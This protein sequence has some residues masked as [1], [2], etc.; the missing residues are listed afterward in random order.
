MRAK[1]QNQILKI[2]LV[3][4]AILILGLSV[5]VATTVAKNK[6]GLSAEASL[7]N[8]Y[9]SVEQALES[10]QEA[11]SQE[12]AS[13][14]QQLAEQSAA[15]ESNEARLNQTIAD[16]NKQ[17]SIKH[18]LAAATAATTQKPPTP[19]VASTQKTPD[20]SGKT[21]Y[22]TFD[23]GPSPRTPEILKI[24]KANG[25]KAT[26]FVINGGKYNAYMKDIVADGH[27]IGLHS[28]SHNY[29]TIYS[30]E[31][32]YF[33]DLQKISDVVYQETG[34]RSEIMR[35]PGGGSNTVSRKYCSGI[36]S[37]LTKRVQEEGYVY[38]DWNLS[39]GD[40]AG[41]NVSANTIINNCRKVPSSKSVVVLMHDA[42]AKR[43]TVEALP[44]VIAY[45]KAAG[46]RFAALDK[47]CATMHQK[48]AN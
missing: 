23:D 28:F 7:S 31:A 29:K 33:T 34:V 43:S 46:C 19:S 5:A 8:D 32:A 25:V 18:S 3:A 14:E 47:T 35:F 6:S 11:R 40:A 20:L 37:R 44:E 13:Y 41:G 2:V 17:I 24:L 30:S 26:F 27:A 45:Y 42:S 36:M 22:L 12:A 38:F 21:I 9:E 4:C 15:H 1:K 48:V 39:S 10:E 16:L